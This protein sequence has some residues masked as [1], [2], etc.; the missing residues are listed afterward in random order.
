MPAAALPATVALIEQGMADGLHIGAQLYV[1]RH[2]EPVADLALGLARPGVAMTPDSLMIWFSCT[3]AVT[4]VAVAQQW[5]QGRIELDAPVARYLPEFGANGKDAVTLRH[6]LTHTG[7]FRNADGG[8]LDPRQ[9]FLSPWDEV[10]A[11]ICAARLEPGWTPGHKAGYHPTSGWFVLGEIV[12]RLDGRPFDRYVREAI[13]EPLGM[14]DCWVGMP[15]EVYRAYGDRIGRMHNTVE[16][17]RPVPV[18]DSEAACAGSVPGG[19]GRGPMRQLARLYE[20]LLGGGV[21]DSVRLLDPRTVEALTARHRVGL[22]DATFQHMLDWSLGLIPNSAYLGRETAPY[23]YGDR[24]S[25]RAV[26][27]SGAQSSAAFMDPEFGL[28]VALVFNGMPGPERHHERMRAALTAVYD[29]LGLAWT[30]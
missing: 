10:I 15:P 9:T 19:N 20:L 13:F 3:K 8:A 18:T 27:H 16:A 11:R 23:G 7:G 25:P 28:V 21:L 2:G 17:P 26:G 14:A 30:P 29:D 24:A 12:R 1:S 4:V 22:F 5:Q 6:V